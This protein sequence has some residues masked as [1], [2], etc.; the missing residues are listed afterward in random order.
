MSKRHTIYSLMKSHD[1]STG[2]VSLLDGEKNYRCMSTV[3]TIT[4]HADEILLSEEQQILLVEISFSDANELNTLA[5]LIQHREHNLSVIVTSSQATIENIR[6]IMRIGVVEY[7][8]QPILKTELLNVLKIAA[9]KLNHQIVPHSG[10]G[11]VFTFMKAGGGSGSTTL[12]LQ[13]AYSLMGQKKKKQETKKVCFLDFDLQFGNA[14]LFLD[15]DQKHS[16]KDVIENSE[17]LDGEYIKSVMAKH[18]SGLYVLPAPEEIIPL[19]ALTPQLIELI[20]NIATEEFDHVVIDIPSSWTMWTNTVLKNSDKIYL[21]M[22]LTVKSIRQSR[23]LLDMVA[24]QGLDEQN[25]NVVANRYQKSFRGKKFI[26]KTEEALRHPINDF[27]ANE[28]AI[29]SKSQDLGELIPVVK[30]RTTIEKQ[31]DGMTA[32]GLKE[33]GMKLQTQLG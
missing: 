23:R 24:N 28:Y 15:L 18:S 27:V 3:G 1:I 9:S 10:H 14:A 13:T 19:E 31:I 25:I 2:I 32:S 11:S 22:Q 5:K 29:V 16:T 12:A 33:I 17:R 6:Q 7:L 8:P 20:I 26:K 30:K 21:V 4:K